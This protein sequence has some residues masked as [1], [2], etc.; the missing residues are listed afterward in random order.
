MKNHQFQQVN[1]RFKWAFFFLAVK[2]TPT[3]GPSRDT[4]YLLL[5]MAGMVPLDP[6][7]KLITKWNVYHVDDYRLSY[8][9]W[10]CSHFLVGCFKHLEKY[11]SQW[12]G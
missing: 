10:G 6:Q 7:S 12:E 11:E 5:I 3:K 2:S 1:R 9:R 4:S 8:E